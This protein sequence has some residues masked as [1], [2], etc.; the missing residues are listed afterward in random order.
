MIPEIGK[1][2]E[3]PQDIKKLHIKAQGLRY[4]NFLA[5]HPRLI[6]YEKIKVIVPEP[7]VFAVHKLIISDRRKK[8]DKKERDREAAVGI[9][10]WIFE[11]PGELKKLRAILK[12]LPKKWLENIVALSRQA[13][14]RLADEIKKI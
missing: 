1:G 8:Q 6:S 4:L 11:Q 12:P 3:K 14:P 9:L 7:A 13:Y 10:D 5:D 2:F